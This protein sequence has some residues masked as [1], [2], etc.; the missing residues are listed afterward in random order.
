MLRTDALAK[1][2]K[3]KATKMKATKLQREAVGPEPSKKA[4]GIEE[5]TR[6]EEALAFMQAHQIVVHGG[7]AILP[8]MQLRAAPFPPPLVVELCSQGF[9]APS[10]VQAAAWPL[11]SAGLDVLAIAKT[12]SG[13]TLGFLLPAIA[14]CRAGRL[15]G[16]AP[17]DEPLALVVVPTRELALQVCA[18]AASFGAALGVRAVAVYGGA[19]KSEQMRQLRRGADIVVATPGRMMDML[20][21][22]NASGIR[23]GAATSLAAASLLVLDEADRMLDMGFEPDFRAIAAALAPPPG[24]QTLLFSATWP[25]ES[26][27]VRRVADELLR[28]T[29]LATVSVGEGAERLTANRDVVQRVHV[30]APAERWGRFVA[31]LEPL[32]PRGAPLPPR[33]LVFANRRKSVDHIG[34]HCWRAG[35]ACDTL[36][37]DRT[38]REREDVLAAFRA[39]ELRM[40]IATDVAARGLDIEGVDRVLNYDFPPPDGGAEGAVGAY[41]HRVG[42][43]GRAGSTGEADTL[44]TATDCRHAAELCRVLAEA[45][46]EV[47]PE[48]EAQSL[49]TH[50]SLHTCRYR[51]SSRRSR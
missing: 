10:A 42:R 19:P 33:V 45:A 29:S 50:D 12:G 5:S 4:A 15:R 16:E 22:R 48:L 25:A 13:K 17:A 44:F 35:F 34:K 46:Q 51:P 40:L 47:P 49:M 3:K 36:H 28:P 23:H 30:V 41:I 20:D 8:C 7:G 18:Q 38:Q 1:R 39:G 11:A 14:R 37:G 27:S 31:L 32:Q 2:I 43:T 21:L 6:R 26:T 24:R 9:A